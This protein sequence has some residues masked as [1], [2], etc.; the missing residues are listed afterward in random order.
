[1]EENKTSTRQF[2]AY[3]YFFPGIGPKR[4]ATLVIEGC[5]L[6][7]YILHSRPPVSYISVKCHVIYRSTAG[8]GTSVLWCL[9]TFS[10]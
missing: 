7:V 1:M 6:F 5:K 10:A 8:I 3:L 9:V 2:A 4:A